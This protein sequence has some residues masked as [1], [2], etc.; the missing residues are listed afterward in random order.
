MAL[1]ALYREYQ[2]ENESHPKAH[3]FIIDH[4][5]RPESTEEASWVAEQLRS[6]REAYRPSALQELT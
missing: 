6:K 5:V 4:G 1:A 2:E 3:G